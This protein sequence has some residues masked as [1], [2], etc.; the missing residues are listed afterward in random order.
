MPWL[1]TA[2]TYIGRLVEAFAVFLNKSFTNLIANGTRSTLTVTYNNLFTYIGTSTSET[3]GT[4][5]MRII[6]YPVRLNIIQP[7]CT[8]FF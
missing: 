8:N 2:I 6:K 4:K 1:V 7:V 3:L 5:V